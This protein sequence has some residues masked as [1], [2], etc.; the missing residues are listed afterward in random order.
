MDEILNEIRQ[1]PED[2]FLL[3]QLVKQVGNFVELEETLEQLPIEE[4]LRARGK[5]AGRQL[6][7]HA[8]Q[9][10][11]PVGSGQVFSGPHTVTAHYPVDLDTA[12]ASFIGWLDAFA[13]RVTSGPHRWNLPGDDL[14][15]SI[16]RLF[17]AD[18]LRCIPVHQR[19][20]EEGSVSLRDFCNREEV[21]IAP[22]VEIIS[23]VDHH[24]A[25]LQTAAAPVV[26]IGDVQSA[27]V[28]VAE[29]Q[30]RLNQRYGVHP[31]RERFETNLLLQAILDDTD[32]LARVTARDVE[33]VAALLGSEV[34]DSDSVEQTARR[35]LSHPKLSTLYG[36]VSATRERELAEEIERCANG[37]VLHLFADTKVQ[38]GYARVGQTKIFPKLY[39]LLQKHLAALRRW[40]HQLAS[41]HDDLRLHLHMVTTVAGVGEQESYDHHDELWIWVPESGEGELKRFLHSFGSASLRRYL[42][43]VEVNGSLQTIFKSALP[44]LEVRELTDGPPVAVIKFDAAAITSRKASITPHL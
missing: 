31:E 2:S 37:E 15:P 11:F 8:Y 39:P 38:K 3:P 13:A 25:N 30:L 35:L 42:R 44:D 33:C 23:V 12:V 32:F 34:S 36:E 18:L 28:L 40:W 22:E 14:H 5:I 17:G 20:I 29:Q 10:F 1:A 19:K 9:A 6:P 4:N 43:G 21:E 26:L 16:E 24:R 27:N 7:R 41:S